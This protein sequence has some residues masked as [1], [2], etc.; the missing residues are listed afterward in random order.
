MDTIDLRNLATD[1]RSEPARHKAGQAERLH[2]DLNRATR[3]DAY[4]KVGKAGRLPGTRPVR[5]NAYVDTAL[6]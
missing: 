5:P 3:P 4:P 6:T 2:T 1:C